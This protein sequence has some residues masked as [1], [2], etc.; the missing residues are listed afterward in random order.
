MRVGWGVGRRGGR[1]AF[2]CLTSA[3]RCMSA[4]ICVSTKRGEAIPLRLGRLRLEVCAFWWVDPTLQ[5]AH[6]PSA[7]PVSEMWPGLFQVRPS[8]SAHEETFMRPSHGMK[9]AF[10]KKEKENENR[11]KEKTK[12]QTLN[13]LQA[14]EQ[15]DKLW[16]SRQNKKKEKTNRKRKSRA[17]LILSRVL[18]FLL[19]PIPSSHIVQVTRRDLSV[20]VVNFYWKGPTGIC[21]I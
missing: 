14:V 4:C 17:L 2:S 15:R 5:E 10:E 19:R 13:C 11:K 20:R 21:L 1:A 6:W 12:K 7:I 3:N 16:C 8:L 9:A 18:V